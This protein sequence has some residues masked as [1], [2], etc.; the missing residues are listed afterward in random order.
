MKFKSK[1]LGKTT[2]QDFIC[3]MVA[4]LFRRQC[5]KELTEMPAFNFQNA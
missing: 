1:Y 2:N 3:N 4:I 5:G